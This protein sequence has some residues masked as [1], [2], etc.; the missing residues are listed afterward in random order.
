[1]SR[2]TLLQS[3]FRKATPI[4]HS[5]SRKSQT[6]CRTSME[7]ATLTSPHSQVTSSSTVSRAH[8]YG[9]APHFPTSCMEKHVHPLD[10]ELPRTAGGKASLR[11]QRA[12]PTCLCKSTFTRSTPR[13]HPEP[14]RL[15]AALGAAEGFHRPRTSWDTIQGNRYQLVKK[16]ICFL[17]W[18]SWR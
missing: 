13:G 3:S 6:V 7:T 2:L 4:S 1:M 18:H 15:C 12:K 5:Q 11:G 10:A 8:L 17:L 14:G 9:D 16:Y